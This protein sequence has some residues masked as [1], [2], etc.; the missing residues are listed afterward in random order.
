MAKTTGSKMDQARAIYAKMKSK[1]KPSEIISAFETQIPMSRAGASTYY[2]NIKRD[3]NK[4]TTAPKKKSAVA[5]KSPTS[6]SPTTT[7]AKNERKDQL[8]AAKDKV[9]A[10]KKG[11]ASTTSAEEA[12]KA[13]AKE[14][15]A[16]VQNAD[17]KVPYPH[18]A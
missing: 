8:K 13:P 4:G 9:S 2:Y 15:P 10:Q 7:S 1:S 5:T 14:L 17:K 18:T 12:P 3:E 11:E 16:E 6:P